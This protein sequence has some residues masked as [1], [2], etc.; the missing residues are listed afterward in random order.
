MLDVNLEMIEIVL[1]IILRDV[2]LKSLGIFVLLYDVRVWL[3][4]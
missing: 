1:K 2:K 4:V 3:L